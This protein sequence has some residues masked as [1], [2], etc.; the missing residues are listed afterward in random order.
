MASETREGV[1]RG[2]ARA[3][4]GDFERCVFERRASGE[5]ARV[6]VPRIYRAGERGS[7]RGGVCA[8]RGRCGC[9]RGDAE[10]VGGVHGLDAA[11]RAR[12]RAPCWGRPSDGA[13]GAA[14]L[15]PEVSIQD[16]EAYLR[17]TRERYAEFVEQRAYAESARAGRATP[18]R[19][20]DGGA[21]GG[22]SDLRTVPE[23]FFDEDFDL[24]RPETFSRTCG[25]VEAQSVRDLARAATRRKRI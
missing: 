4:R 6:R 15:L 25:R 24:S 14:S 3:M 13:R 9:E 8:R 19:G 22:V 2:R 17:K 11:R 10:R 18:T 16:F 23:L 21:D 1:R 5:R 12:W 20:G 7:A